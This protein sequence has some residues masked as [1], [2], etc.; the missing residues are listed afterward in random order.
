VNRTNKITVLNRPEGRDRTQI[1]DEAAKA[2]A[3][4]CRAARDSAAGYREA[5][6]AAQGG[7]M[8][9]R[10]F[11]LARRRSAMAGQLQTHLE[12]HA[13]DA[14]A[15]ADEAVER[16]AREL[17]ARL[18]EGDADAALAQIVRGETAFADMIDNAGR[19][20]LP[21]PLRGLLQRQQRQVRSAVERLSGEAAQD[22]RL[23]RLK[24]TAVRYRRPAAYVLLA[25]ALGAVVGAAIVQQRRHG[26]LTRAMGSARAALDRAVAALAATRFGA[27]SHPRRHL[28]QPAADALRRAGAYLEGLRHG[29]ASRSRLSSLFDPR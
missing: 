19:N 2:L 25:L 14:D 21:A 24:S 15:D 13:L 23:Q 4:L 29:R 5:A 17:K 8:K 3:G 12:N 7:A 9:A 27:P 6:E 11:G 1:S 10:L 16:H 26:A 28:P 20:K 22:S 18:A